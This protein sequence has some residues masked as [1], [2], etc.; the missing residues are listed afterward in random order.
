MQKTFDWITPDWP[1]PK[2]VKACVTTRSGG[3]SQ[4]AWAS[5]NLADR[6][7]D[8]LETVRAGREQ[9]ARVLG[10]KL[11]F[12]QQVHGKQIVPADPDDCPQADASW[13]QM[14][15][16]ACT[17]LTAD[18]LPVL[19]CDAS[20]S[21]VAAAHA[22]WRGLAAGILEQTVQTLAVP[23]DQLLVWLGPCIGQAAF[24][25]GEEVRAAFVDQQAEAKAA[26]IPAP[27]SGKYQADLYQLAY[28]RLAACGVTSVYGGGF[29]T[30]TDKARFYSYRRENPT[31]RMASLIWLAD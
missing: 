13:T 21:R 8:S 16:I 24:E 22:G 7:G 29:C 17:V 20:G 28:L 5:F 2:R 12:L 23:A 18:C 15:G 10:C 26:F 19:F 6:V 1:A 3:L 30:Y 4:G 11:A 27:I 25:V 9:L 14:P 31:G